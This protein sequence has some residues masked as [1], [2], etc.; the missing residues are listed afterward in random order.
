MAKATS[1]KLVSFT[2][3]NKAGQLAAVS[4]LLA[5][6]RLSI[7]AFSAS[8]S[9][10]TAEFTI[11]VKN[12]VKAKKALAPLGVEIKEQSAVC[13]EMANEPGRLHKVTKKLADAGI[14]IQSSWATAFTGKTARGVFVTSDDAK[15]LTAVNKKKK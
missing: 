12:A 6:A 4:E 10:A 3:P 14:N 8:D 2:L 13:V 9:G 7:Q 1:V 5:D 11:A 15:A